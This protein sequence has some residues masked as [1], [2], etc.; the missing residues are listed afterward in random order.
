MK[1]LYIQTKQIHFCGSLVLWGVRQAIADWLFMLMHCGAAE[2]RASM[3][4]SLHMEG[5]IYNPVPARDP[6]L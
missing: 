2:A 5:D 3:C 4:L 1:L 6:S